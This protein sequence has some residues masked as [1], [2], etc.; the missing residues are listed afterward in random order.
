MKKNLDIGSLVRYKDR[1]RNSQFNS[2]VGIVLSLEGLNELK[3]PDGSDI[4]FFAKVAWFEKGQIMSS[5]L[6][7]NSFIGNLEVIN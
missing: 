1:S 5:S 7:L 6:H 3:Q 2:I 4:I